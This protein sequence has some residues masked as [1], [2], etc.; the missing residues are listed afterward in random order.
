[1]VVEKWSLILK[2]GRRL[3]WCE[4]RVLRKICGSKRDEVAGEWKILHNEELYGLHSSPNI[5][6]V[7]KSRRMRRVGHVGRMGDRTCA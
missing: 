1:M 7:I 5:I 3:R 6:R 2:E 4:R